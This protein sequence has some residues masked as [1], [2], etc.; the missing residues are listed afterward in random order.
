MRNHANLLSG[1][2]HA[3]WREECQHFPD[4]FDVPLIIEFSENFIMFK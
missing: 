1:Y 2:C 3:A 4:H